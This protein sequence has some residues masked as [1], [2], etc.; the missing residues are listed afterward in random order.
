MIAAARFLAGFAEPYS[1]N[2]DTLSKHR[3]SEALKHAFA[4]R[5]SLADPT[6]Y[7]DVVAE[8][9][10]DM[11]EGDY[12]ESLRREAFEDGSVLENYEGYGGEKWGLPG[13]EDGGG[14][15]GR[16]EGSGIAERKTLN[17][18]YLEDHGTSHFSIVDKFGNAV[19][20]TT[21]IN[22]E[23]GSK[24]LSPSTGVLFNNEMDD[25]ASPGRPNYF[26]LA[27]SPLNYP[28]GHKRPLS[29]M[30]PTIIFYKGKVRMVLGASGGPKII[31]AT[32]QTFLNHA[33]AGQDLFEANSGPRIHEQLMYHG[34]LTCVYS[35]EVLVGGVELRSKD[36]VVDSMIKRGH[37]ME[38]S[39]YLGSCQAISVDVDGRTS[40]VSD[41]R[42]HGAPAA[43]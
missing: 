41:V 27:P 3:L 6:F 19:S 2:F 37:G 20:I 42:K 26:G 23:F 11:V 4:M 5:M 10:E 28:A 25:F 39:G 31:T 33:L 30:S 9:L 13:G 1:A 14:R 7:P 24:V 43:E 40:A 17:F 29:S 22:T 21:T 34:E 32:L 18:Q 16:E 12:V 8:V 36:L 15:R 35:D 38:P